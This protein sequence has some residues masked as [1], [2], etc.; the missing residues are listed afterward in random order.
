MLQISLSRPIFPY[1]CKS[2]LL[3]CCRNLLILNFEIFM[4][5]SEAF[6]PFLSFCHAERHGAPS[7][8]AKY[9]DCFESWIRPALGSKDLMEI[10][11]LAV[12]EL[13]QA[14]VDKQLSIARQYSVIM[15]SILRSRYFCTQM[16]Q[17]GVKVFSAAGM[18]RVARGDKNQRIPAAALPRSLPRISL[19]IPSARRCAITG[20]TSPTSR[21][22]PGT[23][24]FRLRPAIIWAKTKPYS[25]E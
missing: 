22:W 5:T 20:R 2:P 12:L 15:S 6:D 25:G 9:R 1:L 11:R 18:D 4:K 3:L 10:T 13:R 23:R 21:I 14:M 8:L 16:R 19:G 17:R 7:T 24:T